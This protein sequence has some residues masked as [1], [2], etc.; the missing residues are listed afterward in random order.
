MCY[1]HDDGEVIALLCYCF[2]VYLTGIVDHRTVMLAMLADISCKYYC[3]YVY[4]E[5]DI[6]HST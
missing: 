3:L 5:R 6:V 1:I 2:T 4:R